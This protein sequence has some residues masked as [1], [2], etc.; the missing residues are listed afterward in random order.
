MQNITILAPN[1]DALASFIN[2][3]AGAGA[4]TDPSALAALLTYHVLNGSYPGSAFTNTSAF[5]PTFLSNSSYANVTGGQVVK[6]SLSGTNVSITSGLLSQSRVVTADIA[7]AGGV[8]HVIDSVLTVPQSP[9]STAAGAELTSLTGALTTANLVS[10]V[11]ELRDVTIFAPSNAAFQAIG[12]ALAN[13]STEDLSSILTYH[14]VQGTVGYSSLL[15]NTTLPT[16]NGGSITI[17]VVNGSVFVN[18]A[19]VTLPDVLVSNG[20]V[21]VIDG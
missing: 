13:V 2:S 9:S 18:S 21:H 7:F 12:S 4:S 16:V 8:I 20:V 5:I 15:T 1:N 10:T 11:D 19:K 6:A 14:V 3:T 17:T